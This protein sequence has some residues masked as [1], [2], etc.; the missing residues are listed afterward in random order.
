MSTTSSEAERVH[1]RLQSIHYDVK[2]FL[3]PFLAT[4]NTLRFPVLANERCG[5]WYAH[6]FTS[7]KGKMLS[8][9]F[10][11]ADGHVGTW[12]LSLK[13]LNLNVINIIAK[14][15]AGCLIL[16]ASVRKGLPDSLSRTIPIW[17]AVFNRIVLK[18]RDDLQIVVPALDYWDINLYTPLWLISE[19]EHATISSL[20][21]ER[22]ES[23]YQSG[24]V[25]N[26]K[27]LVQSLTKPL[28]PYWVT[29]DRDTTMPE[30]DERYFSLVCVAC[31]TLESPPTALGFGYIPGAADDHEMWAR[32]LTP[33]LLWDHAGELLSASTDSL[34]PLMD[35]IAAADANQDEDVSSAFD[36][37]GAHDG[38]IFSI[39]S[40]R[41]GRPPACW[42]N[43]DAIMNVTTLEYDDM[44]KE[45]EDEGTNKSY[46]QLPVEEGKRDRNELER[47]MAVGIVFVIQHQQQRNSRILIHCAQGQDRSVAVAMACMVL[48]CDLKDPNIA[49]R[50]EITGLTQKGLYRFAFKE[51][52]KDDEKLYGNSGLYD[53]LVQVLLGRAGR[54]LLF[55][56]LREELGFEEG[57]ILATKESQRIALHLI[58]QH[59]EK[60]SP[61][62]STMQKLN[63]FFMSAQYQ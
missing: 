60:A 6:P 53:R 57:V 7:P 37:I 12:T 29:P 24:A 61:S 19:E 10:K 31:S 17:C 5:T 49:F 42:D 26:P 63:R 22:V 47:W 58:Q 1:N 18:Y 38:G 15:G 48:L 13:R 36:V 11:S 14:H 51:E 34:L 43:F 56:W 39:G 55:R 33:P 41:A 50:E 25:V 2:T 45:V 16:D 32:N 23:L 30:V 46:L 4:N 3:T 8:C 28:R 9:Y 52:M 62:R 27:K 59:R 20:I 21:D 40:R 35:A 54:D 44:K